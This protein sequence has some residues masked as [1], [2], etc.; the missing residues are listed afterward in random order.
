MNPLT[1]ELDLQELIQAIRT[2]GESVLSGK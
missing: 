2:C 1:T